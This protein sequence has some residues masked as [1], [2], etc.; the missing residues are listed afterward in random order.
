MYELIKIDCTK[1]VPTVSARELYGVL[2]IEKRFSAWFKV[3]SQ[4]FIQNE[5]YFNP[6]FEVRVQKEGNRTISREVDD[7]DL[8]VDMAKH[9]CLMSHTP[10]GKECRQLLIELEKAWNTPEQAM[11][12]AL[13][14]AE[15][16]INKFKLEN[17]TLSKENDL[18]AAKH[19][20]WDGR[21][22]INAAVRKYAGCVCS[23][24]FS[25]AWIAFK[26]KNYYTSIVLI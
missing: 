15:Q 4:D 19:L 20:K 18:L 6:Y 3:N 26:K 8:S 10:K 23:G 22:F 13:K 5:D 14:I 24:S 21:N 11:A 17:T 9:I 7:C 25:N 2:G 16:S 1:E 12:R